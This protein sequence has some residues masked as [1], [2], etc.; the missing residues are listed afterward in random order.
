[1]KPLASNALTSGLLTYAALTFWVSWYLMPDPGTVDAAHILTIVG[2]ARLSVLASVLIQ[3]TSSAAYLTA[4]ILLVRD[5]LLGPTALVGA[6]LFGIGVIGLC[7]D[8]FFHLLAYEMTSNSVMVTADVVEVMRLM[9]TEGVIVLLPLLLPFFAGS[10]VLSLGLGRQAM[11]SSVAFIAALAIGAV[12]TNFASAMGYEGR[13][14]MLIALALVALGHAMLGLN[15]RPAH[16][17]R[18]QEA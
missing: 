14:A 5:N 9:Q 17:V 3:I 7:A 15:L 16:Q 2:E 18:L 8:A 10:L 13:A 11:A 1:M 12:G 4:L 6:V